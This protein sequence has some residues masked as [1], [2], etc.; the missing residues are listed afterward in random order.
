[1]TD[2]CKLASFGG[3]KASTATD[4]ANASTIS[5]TEVNPWPLTSKPIHVP[6]RDVWWK[7]ECG[8]DEPLEQ[9]LV[10]SAEIKPPE[11]GSWVDVQQVTDAPIAHISGERKLG[12]II[13]SSFVGGIQQYTVAYSDYAVDTVPITRVT[14]HTFPMVDDKPTPPPWLGD[15]LPPDVAKLIAEKSATRAAAAASAAAAARDAVRSSSMSTSTPAAPAP[16]PS[17]APAPGAAPPPPAAMVMASIGAMQE[18]SQSS[19]SPTPRDETAE[20]QVQSGGARL[21]P[22]GA[23][24]ARRIRPWHTSDSDEEEEVEEAQATDNEGGDDAEAGTG[25]H[26][27][28]TVDIDSDGEGNASQGSRS[29]PGDLGLSN[30][31]REEDDFTA[32]P[33]KGD[34]DAE[35]SHGDS[36]GRVPAD[37]GLMSRVWGF[38]FYA[39]P[40]TGV[41][42]RESHA[43]SAHTASLAWACWLLD[44]LL[45]QVSVVL[46]RG[47]VHNQ[48]MYDALVTFLRTPDVNP[49]TRSLVVSLL[50]QASH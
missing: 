49:R 10:A 31:F 21:R 25:T 50:S 12:Q 43:L 22:R 24:A 30:L 23:R 8:R 2:D 35:S 39:A 28:S 45:N 6:G 4:D 14:P 41:W 32:A 3:P 37:T 7:L 42:S 1:M 48:R 20:V 16:A 44:F 47:A 27:G 15:N 33:R 9:L 19:F 26:D 17:P 38:A 36:D 5:A 34:A 40:S 46:R 18:Q 11:A 13:A 29:I